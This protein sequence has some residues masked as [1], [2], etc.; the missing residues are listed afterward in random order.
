MFED[1]YLLLVVFKFDFIGISSP[2]QEKNCWVNK[3]SHWI[4]RKIWWIK[5]QKVRHITLIS[6]GL[7]M[8]GWEFLYELFSAEDM[9]RNFISVSM[10]SSHLVIYHTYINLWI[11]EFTMI[12]MNF[13]HCEILT[14]T[15]KNVNGWL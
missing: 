12:C 10:V 13:S 9:H 7:L 15:L 8:F 4:P 14:W 2:S 1:L 11:Y 6:E 3:N 5:V